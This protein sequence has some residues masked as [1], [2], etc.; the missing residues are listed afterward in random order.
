MKRLVCALAFAVCWLVLLAPRG[1]GQADRVIT[2]PQIV[3]VEAN[4]LSPADEWAL[5]FLAAFLPPEDMPSAELTADHRCSH[6]KRLGLKSKVWL[7]GGGMGERRPG[8]ILGQRQANAR[9][10]RE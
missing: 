2:G 6:C 1:N 8:E 7:D 4:V 9:R 5:I 3:G 10:Q